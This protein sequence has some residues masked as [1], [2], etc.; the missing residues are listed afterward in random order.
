MENRVEILFMEIKTSICFL[1]ISILVLTTMTWPLY[2]HV[3]KKCYLISRNFSRSTQFFWLI[4]W[5][6]ITRAYN[7]PKLSSIILNYSLVSIEMEFSK[8]NKLYQQTIQFVDRI[9]QPSKEPI[10]LTNSVKI[11]TTSIIDFEK[12]KNT[13]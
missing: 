4:Y 11:L 6:N 1:P 10:I 2:N 12:Q 9:M 3:V 5:N 7:L 8:H 13:K